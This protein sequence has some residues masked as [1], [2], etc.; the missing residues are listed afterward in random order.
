MLHKQTII[1]TPTLESWTE[2]V[3]DMVHQLIGTCNQLSYGEDEGI[4]LMDDQMVARLM[5][6]IDYKVRFDHGL[7]A[8]GS[9]HPYLKRVLPSDWN[10]SK[11]TA[12]DIRH[13]QELDYEQHVDR[14]WEESRDE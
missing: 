5:E 8:N 7:I 11:E 13:A 12:Y 6:A 4:A 9:A 3:S 2:Q 1:E 14:Q 10:K